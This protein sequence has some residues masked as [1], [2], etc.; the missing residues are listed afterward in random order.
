MTSLVYYL[1][2]FNFALSTISVKHKNISVITFDGFSVGNQAEKCG[3]ACWTILELKTPPPSLF[4]HHFIQIQT[5]ETILQYT[6]SYKY[7]NKTIDILLSLCLSVS[8]CVCVSVC[9]CVSVCLC[10][11][12]SL[13][14]SVSLSLCL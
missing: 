11:S 2:T 13:C 1:K 4:W 14:V 6:I 5:F 8:L 9:Q 10:L 7:L 3:Q 12:V